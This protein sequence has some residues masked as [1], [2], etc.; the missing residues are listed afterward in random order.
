MYK[1]YINKVKLILTSSDMLPEFSDSKPDTKVALYSGEIKH[2]KRIIWD[3]ETMDSEATIILHFNDYKELLKDFKSFYSV[4]GAGG[5]LVINELD[6]ILFIYRRGFWD[7]PKGKFEKKETK[8]ETALREVREE[9]GVKSL[10]IGKKIGITYH[11]FKNRLGKRIIK[12]SYWYEIYAPKQ[13]TFPQK[14]E[15]ITEASWM[16]I[17]YFE[18]N[19]TPVFRNI[20]D[21]VKVYKNQKSKI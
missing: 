20:I 16:T 3:C 11:T 14:S 7:L 10:K 21:I 9:T 2:M 6:E 8:K 17:E 19:A 12:K 4:V 13:K 5:G 15:D 18:A 1:I